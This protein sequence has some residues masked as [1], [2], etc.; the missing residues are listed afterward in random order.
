VGDGA[1]NAMHATDL[2]KP[3]RI[4]LILRQIDSLPTLPSVATRLLQLTSDDETQTRQVVELVSSDPALT[5][6]VLSLC[7][8]ADRGLR[9]DVV[10]VDRAVV[11][12]GFN[13]IRNAVLSI[14]VFE[15]FGQEKQ[16]QDATPSS[17]D[18]ACDPFNRVEFWR[19]SLAV[20]IAAELIAREHGRA[21]ELNPDEAFVCG[22]L[23]DIGKLALDH[24]LP[25]AFA[26]VITL[27]DLNQ[28]DIAEIERRIV[29]IDHHTAGKRLAEQWGLPHTLQDCI[30]LH[31]SAYETLPRLEHKRLI[32]LIGLADLVARR[33]HVG[34][35]GNYVFRQSPQKLAL[36]L[37]IDP[38]CIDRAVA[39]LHEEL[40][41]R[42]QAMGLHDEPSR[43]L[44]LQ[45]I[46]RANEQLGRL[47]AALDRRGAAAASQARILAAITAFHAQAAPG[48]GVQQVLDD[49]VVS[50]IGALGPGFYAVL[51]QTPVAYASHDDGDASD[52]D[53][54]AHDAD[55]W[56]IAQYDE[57]GRLRNTQVF[58][59][60]PHSPSLSA[61]DAGDPLSLNVMG[62]LPWAADYLLD[63]EDLRRIRMLPLSSGWGTAAVLLHDHAALPPWRELQALTTTW[64]ATIAGSLQHDGA[65]RLGEAL[66]DANRALAQAQDRLLQTESLARLG[67]MA[68]GAA[69]EM[70]NP[71]AVIAGRSQLLTMSLD[72]GTREQA[73]A[74]T[75]FEQAHRLSDLITALR[76]IADPPR[77]QRRPVDLHSVLDEAI[78]KAQTRS[79]KPDK[80]KPVTFKVKDHL[81]AVNIDPSMVSGAVTE[82]V[83]NALAATPK[84]MVQV[85]AHHDADSE[86]LVIQ[87]TD[88][89]VGM[90]DYTLAHALDPFFSVKPAGRQMGMGLP[91]A[92]QWAAAHG[93]DL[94]LRS[95]PEVG[96]VATLWVPLTPPN[97]DA[98]LPT[99][100]PAPATRQRGRK[101]SLSRKAAV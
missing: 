53:D 4:E 10:T 25:K 89:G 38:A 74:Q 49:V 86:R 8:A 17:A 80:L 85:V 27:C 84:R 59:P 78:K 14:K 5:A 12:L 19:H 6:K 97:V 79:G 15:T 61:I 81:P 41:R 2:S 98:Q 75:I 45:S 16:G 29:G 101:A 20:A 33:H 100:P 68:A 42:G 73:A 90:D 55:G 39:R 52:A 65:R 13:A 64:G 7:R 87:V 23:H 72:S 37:G 77:A 47:N 26:R 93:G 51:M 11:L 30:W 96:T 58:T 9:S 71:L 48:R 3:R 83:C 94:E 24:V 99:A 46:Q 63:A 76:M 36:A 21:D 62:I 70:N 44:F 50:A 54:V 40:E 43:E 22:L 32:G 57:E 28:G 95:T 56:F 69:H 35:S 92:K 66:A 88:D 34:Y 31:G 1:L 91:R 18:P 60:P 82:L 67:E